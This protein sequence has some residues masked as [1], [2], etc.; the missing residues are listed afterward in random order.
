MTE[1]YENDRALLEAVAANS[2][3][4]WNQLISL[5]QGR[6][7]HFARTRIPT[8][9]DAEDRVQETFVS[10]LNR[11]VKGDGDIENLEAY[12][13]T[14]LRHAIC[15]QY[16][17]RWSR[18]VCLIQDGFQNAED[19]ES[20]D[21]MA[22]L[23]AEELSASWHVSRQEEGDR[24]YR[25]LVKALKD[26]VGNMKRNLSFHDLKLSDLLFYSRLTAKTVAALMNMNVTSVRVFK[27]RLIR[28]FQER[29]TK[30]LPTTES[31]V[32]EPANTLSD[33]WENC[34]PTC[35]KYST[36]GKFI[37]EDLDP[38]WFD[39][40]DFH[41]TTFGCHFCR[42]SYKDLISRGP[43]EVSATLQER[44]LHSTIGFFT[45]G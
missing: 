22:L 3:A 42:A 6:L 28:Q 4:A 24:Q 37:Q 9:A 33:T 35:P 11:L 7:L 32:I 34:R 39:Y 8:S 2:E 25:I 13:F 30:D 16:R 36:L 23:P 31:C 41:L 14:I 5:Y 1:I 10:L 12:L 19:G 17:S 27:H 15:T 29:I 44:I 43:S 40:I 20:A 26:I 45:Q 38:A 21:A 18:S